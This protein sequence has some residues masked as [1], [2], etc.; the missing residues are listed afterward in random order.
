[1]T[2]GS[3][4]GPSEEKQFGRG[5]RAAVPNPVWSPSAKSP[6]K[7]PPATAPI[8]RKEQSKTSNQHETPKI[9]RHNQENHRIPY[10]EPSYFQRPETRNF[11]QVLAEYNSP[12]V[13][14]SKTKFYVIYIRECRD[15]FSIYILPHSAFYTRCPG[16][17]ISLPTALSNGTPELSLQPF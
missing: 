3:G 9:Q 15:T 8:A 5:L 11:N 14:Q 12:G 16:S 1:M 6:R 7:L 2:A 17:F 13:H 10:Q 4:E